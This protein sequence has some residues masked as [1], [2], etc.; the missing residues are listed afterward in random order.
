[1]ARATH[2]HLGKKDTARQHKVMESKKD[3]SYGKKQT[4]KKQAGLD[5]PVYFSVSN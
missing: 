3:V 1:M 2:Q 4:K 5:F